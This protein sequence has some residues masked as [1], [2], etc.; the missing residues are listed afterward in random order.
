MV[1]RPPLAD[2]QLKQIGRELR[3]LRRE[4]NAALP[5]L[6]DNYPA[7]L[8]KAIN[9]A[10]NEDDERTL[11]FLL[12]FPIKLLPP[13]NDMAGKFSELRDKWHGRNT[14]PEDTGHTP[15]S[16]LQPVA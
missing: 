3:E 12:E 4:L 1:G 10:L 15:Q 5:I 8:R 6:M 9:R 16:G 2:I 11:R 7:L 14:P 13:D